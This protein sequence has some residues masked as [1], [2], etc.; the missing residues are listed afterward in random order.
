MEDGKYQSQQF[1]RSAD[2][3]SAG[4]FN[5]PIARCNHLK[6]LPGAVLDKIY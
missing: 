1:Y 6:A 3:D 5:T 2:S 4:I